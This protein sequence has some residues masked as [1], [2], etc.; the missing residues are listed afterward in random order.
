MAR[1]TKPNPNTAKGS[2]EKS[3]SKAKP[4]DVVEPQPQDAKREPASS[5][6]GKEKP[7]PSRTTKPNSKARATR[8]LQ[9]PSTPEEGG[10]PEKANKAKHVKKEE[11]TKQKKKDVEKTVKEPK[12]ASNG[13]EKKALRS[14]KSSAYHVA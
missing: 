14:R 8:S 4:H 6:L 13:T 12:S 1:K 7:L 10:K 11:K 5:S 3:E 9:K 2:E